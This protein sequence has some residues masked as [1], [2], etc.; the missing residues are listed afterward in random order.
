MNQFDGLMIWYLKISCKRRQETDKKEN[1]LCQKT[2]FICIF[3]NCWIEY[4]QKFNLNGNQNE[5]GT[6]QIP[7]IKC[8]QTLII[9]VYELWLKEIYNTFFIYFS[10]YKI[11]KQSRNCLLQVFEGMIRVLWLFI[12]NFSIHLKR[13]FLKS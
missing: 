12:N 11:R 3:R 2:E 1:E 7:P 4:N 5:N 10:I 8:K 13:I 6:P 9:W